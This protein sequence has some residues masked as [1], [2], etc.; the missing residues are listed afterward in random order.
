METHE[1][2]IEI[3]RGGEIRIHVKGVK[4]PGCMDYADLFET[5]LG[6]SG[7]R[8]QTSEYY[9]QPTGVEIRVEQKTE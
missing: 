2:D 6:A 9:E 8:E 5:I 1:F 3:K 4:G 7:T